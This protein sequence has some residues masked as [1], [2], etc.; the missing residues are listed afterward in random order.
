MQQ[1][2]RKNEKWDIILEVILPSVRN[3]IFFNKES[4][5]FWIYVTLC[6]SLSPQQS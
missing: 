6:R 5:D 1:Q 2:V 4:G 3:S